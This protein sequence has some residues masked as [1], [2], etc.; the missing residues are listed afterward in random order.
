MMAVEVSTSP[1]LTVDPPRRGVR[2]PQKGRGPV[3]RDLP[4][5]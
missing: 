4:G 3:C 1:T 2:V 5:A